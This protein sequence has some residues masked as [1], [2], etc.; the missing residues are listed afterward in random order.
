MRILST[1]RKHQGTAEHSPEDG[2]HFGRV[3]TAGAAS[4]TYEAA[5]EAGLQSAFEAAVDD[6]LAYLVEEGQACAG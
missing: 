3:T 1:Y 5:T 4:L 6:F 2:C